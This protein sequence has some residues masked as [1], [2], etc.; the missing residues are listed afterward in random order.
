MILPA[1]VAAGAVPELVG[2][3]S[4]PSAAAAQRNAGF[5]RVA[6]SAEAVIADEAVGV[7]A[8]CTRHG[9][10]AELTARALRAG[11]HVFCE[12]PLALTSDELADV[13]EA[14]QQSPGI[15]A[16]GF[17]RR[18]APMVERLRDFAGELPGPVTCTI[19]VAAGEL[20]A[21]HWT[22]DLAQGGGRLLGEGCHFV[23]TIVAIARSPVVEVYARGFSRHGLPLQA[24]DNALITLTLENGSQGTIA[25]LADGSAK[26]GKER[27][28]VFTGGRTGVM[29]DYVTLS[30]YDGATVDQ[31]RSG[32]QDKG[33]YA[34]VAAFVAGVRSGQPPVPLAEVANVSLATL[35]I[36]ESLR[37]GLP[38]RLGQDESP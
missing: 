21:D 18:F 19:R 35:A 13:L 10:H 3:G 1:F 26:V 30:L 22:H 2:G 33:H 17:N 9:S 23:D 5:A 6:A 11:K 27:I 32:S 28:E 20:A 25:Y 34:E 24:A 16:V 12:K 29:D 15:L 14:G 8:V 31:E 37:T 36:I 38:V 4:G 7:V